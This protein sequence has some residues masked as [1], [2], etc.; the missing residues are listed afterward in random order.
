[1]A[2][3][4]RR[5][6]APVR[7][8]VAAVLGAVATF[9]ILFGVG[10][11]SWAIVVLGLAMMVLAIAL[12]LVTAVRGG[13]RAWVAGSAHVVSASEPPPNSTYGRCELQIVVDAPG[14]PAAAVKVRD[15]RVPV[16]KWPDAGMTLPIMVAVDDPRHVRVQW[17]DVFTHAERAAADAEAERYAHVDD[18]EFR[19]EDLSGMDPLSHHE[20]RISGVDDDLVD[21][22]PDPETETVELGGDADRERRDESVVVT[23]T[24]SGPVIE[25]T[26][27]DTTHQAG[28]ETP[29]RPRPRP[30]YPRGTRRSGDSPAATA[31]AT[32][33][34]GATAAGMASGAAAGATTATAG[35]GTAVATD[36]ADTAAE[37]EASPA[38]PETS[39][40]EPEASLAEAAAPAAG[41]DTERTDDEVLAQLITAYPSARPGP[42]GSIHG[43]GITMLVTDLDR[44]I[45]FYRDMLG[46]YEIDGGEGNAVLASGDTRLVLRTVHGGAP[47]NRRVVH[48]NLEVGDVEAVYEELK[49]KGVRF[50]HGPRSVN[51]GARLELWAATFRDPDGHGIAITQWRG[52]PAG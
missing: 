25:G 22:S 46:F 27:V 13:A 30:R 14:V 16:A 4:G 19:T 43:V 52:R 45:A 28:G 51:R 40:A 20:D 39:P 23:Q 31:S 38:E 50:T 36:P 18:S 48:V 26:A 3:G 21:G 44:S 11:T 6:I 1:M 8:L 2:N 5:S 34:S 37:E 29:P 42:T 35:G 47:V 24:P 7:R 10:M 12:V 41:R 33:A 9:V 32:G 15:P 17:D 49:A